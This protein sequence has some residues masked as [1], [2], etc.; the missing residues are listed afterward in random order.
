MLNEARMSEP[1]QNEVEHAIEHAIEPQIQNQIEDEDEDED[2]DDGIDDDE[3]F[4]LLFVCEHATMRALSRVSREEEWSPIEVLVLHMFRRSTCALGPKDIARDLHC[5]MAYA[6][7]VVNKL[8]GQGLVAD[9]GGAWGQYLSLA[10]TQ[11]GR[12]RLR[13]GAEELSAFARGI[14]AGLSAKERAVLRRVL[15]RVHANV[16]PRSVDD[17]C[18]DWL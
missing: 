16:D 10:I 4:R 5:S 14:F 6:S 18:R 15:E 11:A 13:R 12:D 3:L 7:K 17:R 2:E 9:T 8:R 1:I